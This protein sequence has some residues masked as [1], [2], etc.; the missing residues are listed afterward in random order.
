M[1]SCA[2]TAERVRLRVGSCNEPG[3]SQNEFTWRT[4]FTWTL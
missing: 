3:G 4:L 2:V 1:A